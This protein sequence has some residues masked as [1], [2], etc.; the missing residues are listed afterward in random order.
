DGVFS[1]TVIL[2]A[3]RDAVAN[4][5]AHANLLGPRLTHVV[6]RALLGRVDA[7]LATVTVSKRGVIQVVH[8]TFENDEITTRIDV[9]GGPPRHFREIVDVYVLADD[10][11]RLGEHHEP[12][13]P[14]GLH[15]LARLTGIPLAD[16]NDD[17]VVKHA[18]GRHVHVHE[19]GQHELHDRQ[20]D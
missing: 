4:L 8:R 12:H 5:G 1:E 14:Q 11:D 10:H 20:E 19:L 9:A 16:R 3:A 15:D 18:F 6:E 2:P 17:H 7:Q 13:A